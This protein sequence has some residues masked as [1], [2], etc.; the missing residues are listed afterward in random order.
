M[1]NSI[2]GNIYHHFS[3][4]LTHAIHGYVIFSNNSDL[5]SVWHVFESKKATHSSD[6]KMVYLHE[7]WKK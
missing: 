6:I 1:F 4:K 7:L 5:H 3:Y 2:C